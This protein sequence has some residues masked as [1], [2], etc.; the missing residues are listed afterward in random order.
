[1][2]NYPTK[3]SDAELVEYRL[4][5]AEKRIAEL[6]SQLSKAQE[7]ISSAQHWAIWRSFG[8]ALAVITGI[9]GAAL[10]ITITSMAKS[11][12][13]EEARMTADATAKEVAGTVSVVEA[14]RQLAG[15]EAF[16]GE[17]SSTLERLLEN[18]VV[19]FLV[20]DCPEGWSAFTDGVGKVVIG[21]GEDGKLIEKRRGDP[22]GSPPAILSSHT[23]GDQGGAEDVALAPAEMPSHGHVIS[24][25]IRAEADGAAYE[26]GGHMPSTMVAL[27]D[28]NP[29]LAGKPPTQVTQNTGGLDDGATKPHENMPPYIALT[30]CEKD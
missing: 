1:M 28:S 26:I 27:D 23:L 20:E 22:T 14:A 30:F 15:N 4:N 25:R 17:V 9:F 12:A 2:A 8:G 13:Q 24:A 21:A 19:A 3:S 6:D 11:T 29:H 16:V 5:E 10:W 7:E 18:S